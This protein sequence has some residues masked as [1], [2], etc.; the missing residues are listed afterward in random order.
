[1]SDR[2]PLKLNDVRK[3]FRLIAEIRRR[4]DEPNDWRPL[5]VRGVQSIFRA[6]LVVSSELYV[7]PTATPGAWDVFDIGWGADTTGEPWRIESKSRETDPKCYDIIVRGTDP[8]EKRAA[9]ELTR[10]LHPGTSF[11]LSSQP[12]PHIH[13]IDQLGIHRGHGEERFTGSDH[14]LAQL[15]HYELG[16]F[17]RA[18]VLS[19][20]RDPNRSL[21]PRLRQTLDLLVRGSSEKQ[22]ALELTI[23]PHTVHNYVKALHARFNVCSRGELI[24]A[25]NSREKQFVPRLSRDVSQAT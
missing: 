5:L 11:I 22:I 10:K 2:A 7:E 8:A 12:L 16:R 14:R 9:I 18:D 6:E 3:V 24:A 23:S 17:W 21:A 13:A 20:T 1:M 4:G 15:L 19:R 25:A